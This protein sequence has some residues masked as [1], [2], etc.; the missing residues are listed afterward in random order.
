MSAASLKEEGNAAL[1]AGRTSE[2]VDFYS[3][4]I[5]LEP[6]N[7]LLYSNRAAALAVLGKFE[8]ALNDASQ[9][10]VLEPLWLKVRSFSRGMLMR[11]PVLFI[12]Y[13]RNLSPLVT[14]G[15][16]AKGRSSPLS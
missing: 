3:R 10:V 7:H 14:A 13:R 15:P 8:E 2:A 1:K 16:R 6:R 11:A 4:A 12:A 5:K 9:V